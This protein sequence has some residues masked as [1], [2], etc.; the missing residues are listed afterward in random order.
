MSIPKRTLVEEGPDAHWGFPVSVGSD[1]GVGHPPTPC[2]RRCPFLPKEA[3]WRPTNHPV[4]NSQL[5]LVLAV[6]ELL[7]P[8]RSPFQTNL[9]LRRLAE[10]IHRSPLRSPGRREAP[11]DRSLQL[12]Q[13]SPWEQE[14]SSP[15]RPALCHL[16][17][18]IPEASRVISFRA[19]DDPP[20]ARSCG[21]ESLETVASHGL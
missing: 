19:P 20:G 1:R 21:C 11:S 5:R 18:S 9:A 8:L 12:P 15:G 16:L 4:F 17:A 14:R 10:S 6:D 7:G 2:P 3:G 13:E